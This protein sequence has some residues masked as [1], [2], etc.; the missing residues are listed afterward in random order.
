M[1]KYVML[2]IKKRCFQDIKNLYYYLK[3]HDCSKSMITLIVMR[4]AS[5]CT[6]HTAYKM[7]ISLKSNKYEKVDKMSR[8]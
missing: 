6:G 7:N 3:I 2:K 5:K 4:S 1:D 8:T